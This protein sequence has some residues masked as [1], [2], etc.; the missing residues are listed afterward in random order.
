MPRPVVP[1]ACSGARLA[2]AFFLHVVGE[3]DV[4]MVADDQ[5]VADGDAGRAE[6]GDFFE[7]ARRI[8]DDAVADDRA[9]VGAED[10]GRQQRELEGLSPLATT[11]WPAL[12][13]PL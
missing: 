11:V 2:Q 5:V 3:D 9:D 13:P 10:A 6:V 8:D 1:M 4:G 12:A 7:E